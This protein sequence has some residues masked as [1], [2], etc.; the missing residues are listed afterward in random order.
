MFL[1]A[2]AVYRF[3]RSNSTRL[4]SNELILGQTPTGVFY[5][6]F[7]DGT[8]NRPI[9]FRALLRRG[10]IHNS[11]EHWKMRFRLRGFA[12]LE[13]V[14]V[15]AIIAIVAALAIPAFQ[16][17]LKRAVKMQMP[18]LPWPLPKASAFEVMPCDL[19]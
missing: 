19:L 1:D 5:T 3:T 18:E 6:K 10:T 14:V 12:L 15:L 11:V 17:S 9:G 8:W 7:T 2:T 4:L 16:S 13:L